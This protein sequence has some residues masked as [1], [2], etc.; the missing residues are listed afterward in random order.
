MPPARETEVKVG[1]R[2]RM[3][4]LSRGLSLRAAAALAGVT[5][6][7]LSQIERDKNSPSVGTL[8]R[9]LSAQGTT[10]GE[11]FADDPQRP[12]ESGFAYRS[13]KLVNVASGRGLKFLTLPGPT[14]GRALQLLHEYY[15]PGAGTGPES[16]THAGEEAGFCL[17]GSIEITVGGRREVLGPGDA[18][19]YAS[20][21]AEPHRWQNIGRVPAEV[22]SA[23]TPPSF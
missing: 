15:A 17:A 14:T 19:Y 6:A 4:R 16:Y 13:N 18:Y 9:I 23:C 21:S 2:L 11:F 10:L 8:K 7:A 20:A 3:L 12:P 5:P 1:Q 22:V